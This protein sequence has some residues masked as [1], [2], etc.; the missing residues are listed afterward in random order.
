M[1]S[2]KIYSDRLTPEL[3]EVLGDE[4]PYVPFGDRLIVNGKLTMEGLQGE[5][6]R[7][8]T[9]LKALKRHDF[10]IIEDDLDR[11]EEDAFTYYFGVEECL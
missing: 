10:E 11:A 9:H 1:L 2:Y 8:R 4:A 3:K 5:V 7:F 6:S